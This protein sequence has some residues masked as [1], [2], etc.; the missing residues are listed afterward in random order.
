MRCQST[1]KAELVLG[2]LTIAVGVLMLLIKNRKFRIGLNIAAIPIGI[3]AFLFP[4]NIT[5]VCSK[6]H[7]TCRSLTLPMLSLISIVLVVFAGINT[8][9][10]WK[11]ESKGEIYDGICIDFK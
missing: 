11:F 2:I 6:V 9:Y 7:M 5:G 1:A 10:L 3:L 8:V 4:N